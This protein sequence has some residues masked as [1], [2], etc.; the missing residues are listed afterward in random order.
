MQD[1]HI[2][3]VGCSR[4]PILTM[5]QME[6][7]D[8]VVSC[9][10]NLAVRRTLYNTTLK[11]LDL[12]AQGR[13]AALVT[14]MADPALYDNYLPVQKVHFHAKQELGWNCKECESNE[15]Y[16]CRCRRTMD[17]EVFNN[18]EVKDFMTFNI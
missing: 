2:N 17:S 15:C 5:K 10:D 3:V 12:R 4:Y 18:E 8:L 14:H 1:I 16:D 11:W 7:Y 6:G 13:N 9:V